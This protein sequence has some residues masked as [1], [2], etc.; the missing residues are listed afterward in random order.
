M[1]LRLSRS[2][3]R[4]LQ[5]SL[6]TPRP[7]PWGPSCICLNHQERRALRRVGKI[8]RQW[9]RQVRRVERKAP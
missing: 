8:V 7:C 3:L 4:L 5:L 9:K 1:P 2:S 6:V